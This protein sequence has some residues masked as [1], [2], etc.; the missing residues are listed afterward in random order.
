MTGTTLFTVSRLLSEWERQGVIQ[1]GRER[2]KIVQRH[3]LVR[4]AEG[5]GGRQPGQD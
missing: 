1:T 3:E 5:H 4:I 2:I